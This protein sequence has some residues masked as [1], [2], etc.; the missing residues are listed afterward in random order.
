MYLEKVLLSV[1]KNQLDEEIASKFVDI[2]KTL[3]ESV[4]EATRTNNEIY[5]N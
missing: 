1:E 4:T 5:E 2:D 3:K